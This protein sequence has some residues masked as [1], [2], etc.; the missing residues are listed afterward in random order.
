VPK[1]NSL[2]PGDPHTG[3][4]EH[5]KVQGEWQGRGAELLGLRGNVRA[6]S[7]RPSGKGCTRKPVNSFGPGTVR[8][9][10]DNDGSEQIDNPPLR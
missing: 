8:T 5:R 1:T 7:L 9:G 2:A 4:D 3:Y 6:N 10:S